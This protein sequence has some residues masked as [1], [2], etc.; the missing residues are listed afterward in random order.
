MIFKT[1]FSS[2]II[3]K[4]NIKGKNLPTHCG[5]K[6]MIKYN[7]LVIS[8]ENTSFSDFPSVPSLEITFQSDA[9]SLLKYC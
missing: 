4:I 9:I 2:L 5:I 7:I 8:T 6:V 3:L 1:Y